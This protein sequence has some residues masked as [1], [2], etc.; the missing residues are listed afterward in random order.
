MYSEPQHVSRKYI[1]VFLIRN[2]RTWLV[3]ILVYSIKPIVRGHTED[4][5]FAAGGLSLTILNAILI[6][7]ALIVGLVLL[8]TVLSYF[9]MTWQVDGHNVI[10]QKGILRR[11]NKSIPI[12]K[13]QSVDVTATLSERIFQTA[14]VKIDTAGG[15]GEDGTIYCL[16]KADASGLRDAVFAIKHGE[17]PARELLEVSRK[18]ADTG[19]EASPEDSHIIYRLPT[20][21]L[22]LTGISNAKAIVFAFIIVSTIGRYANP[23]SEIFLGGEDITGEAVTYLEHLALPLLLLTAIVFFAISWFVSVLAVMAANYGFT[24]CSNGPKIEIEKGLITHK[25]LSIEKQRVQEVRIRQGVIRR[26]IG[27]AEITVKTATLTKKQKK[28]SSR[29]NS[30]EP[31]FTTTIHPF[32]AVKEIEYFISMLLP[33][34]AGTPIELEPLPKRAYIRSTRRYVGWTLIFLGAGW[35]AAFGIIATVTGGEWQDWFLANPAL[36]ILTSLPAVAFFWLTG[37]R[38][39]HGKGVAWNHDFIVIRNGAWAREWARIPRRKI[40]LAVV[41]ENPFQRMKTLATITGTTGALKFP[42]LMDVDRKHAKEYLTWAVT[43]IRSEFRE[44]S[45]GMH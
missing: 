30:D 20:A 17:A 25:T 11:V 19:F 13:I 39:F 43:K 40:Q 16:D 41:H 10:I 34:F 28:Y 45:G 38:S 8:Y 14:T 18:S 26:L 36:V 2:V 37:H 42:S 15:E 9:L 1:P 27:Y 35:S 24:V 32:I 33:D 7:I 22:W 23:F 31:M 3:L 4:T 6:A 44:S 5:F 12:S 21:N 29:S